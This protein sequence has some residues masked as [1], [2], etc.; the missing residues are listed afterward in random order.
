MKA[1]TIDAKW[2]R[3]H[4]GRAGYSLRQFAE[5][6]GLDPANFQR[7]LG[8]TRRVQ[9]A[10]A[11][12]IA[13]LLGHVDASEVFERVF[14][15]KLKTARVAVAPAARIAVVAEPGKAP[16]GGSVDAATG[17][18]TFVASRASA[19]AQTVALTVEGDP[20]MRGWRVL[21]VPSDVAGTPAGDVAAG[22]VQTKGGK[23]LL[24]KIRP[25]FSPGHFDLGP[26]F[27]FGA[28]E[29]GVAVTGI[30]PVTGMEF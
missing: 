7:V 6:L 12:K 8:G 23:F 15:I 2:L 19:K 22:I 24:R 20:F 13:Q 16:I 30:M 27:G 14:G 25:G 28:Q 17:E 4:I 18:V 3:L 29:N 26:L 5:K 11:E 10:E 1:H 21:C 9:P